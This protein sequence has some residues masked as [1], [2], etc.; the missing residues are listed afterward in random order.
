MQQQ[1]SRTC[2]LLLFA[3]AGAA[4][5]SDTPTAPEPVSF[6]DVN[7]LY[8]SHLLPGTA[9]PGAAGFCAHHMLGSSFLDVFHDDELIRSLQMR[10]DEQGRWAGTAGQVPTDEDLVA[11]IRDLTCCTV[12]GPCEPTE[13]LFANSVPLS[14]VGTVTPP[15]GVLTHGVSFRIS[16]T[17]TIIP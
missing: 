2:W 3:V 12:E 8:E 10:Q 16:R 13:G 15:G 17:G 5:C 14:H 4:A 1:W 7:F 11:V 9:D 6:L